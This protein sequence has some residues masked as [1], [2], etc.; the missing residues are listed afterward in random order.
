MKSG[1][2]SPRRA[3]AT[4]WI[5]PTSWLAAWSATTAAPSDRRPPGRPSGQQPAQRVHRQRVERATLGVVPGPGV[6]HRRVLDRARQQP[7]SLPGVPGQQAEHAEVD[8]MGAARGEG[9]PRRAG[10]RVPP[11][12]PRGRCPGGVRASRAGPC[13]R[14][15]SAYPR[16]ER[17]L[18]NGPGRR[19]QRLARRGVE[20][21][22]RAG[23]HRMKLA[24]GDHLSG[25]GATH[26]CPTP[27]LGHDGRRGA[28]VGFGLSV[29][30][31]YIR[32]RERARSWVWNSPSVRGSSPSA[33]S[34][35]RHSLLLTGCSVESTQDD[36]ASRDARPGHRG[37]ARDIL[38]LWQGAWIAAMVDRVITW[39][40]I[41]YAVFRLPPPQ[42]DEI[43]VQTRY[44]L[45]IE[46][47]YTVAPVMMVIVFFFFTVQ[48][49][50]RR[51]ARTKDLTQ[52][53]P[54][55]T[56]THRRG[57]AVVVDVQLHQRPGTR[58]SRQPQ[59][60]GLR[61]RHPG[62]PADAVAGQGRDRRLHLYSPDV[63]HSFWVPA[64]LF[65]MDVVPGRRA[66]TSPSPR[67]AS[68]PSTVAAPSCAASTTRG[69]CSR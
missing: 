1:A 42:R 34:P 21:G 54:R 67:A 36:Q 55:P 49:P 7:P 45:P 8:G 32:S 39:G 43:P 27:P 22:G 17:L 69:C 23:A 33:S 16:V 26:T 24:P 9:R 44:N 47:F 20:V 53:T 13:R 35:D 48:D 25:R 56:R 3:S 46:I 60:G 30:S 68:A 10:R 15:G 59:P 18:E 63:I 38:D 61:R 4:G 40:L 2:R 51:P 58:T 5:V 64:F 65:K 19:V 62:R 50:G 12:W 37:S 31:R 28:V 6:H 29:S 52:P 57:P 11:R 14:R 41:F 66:T